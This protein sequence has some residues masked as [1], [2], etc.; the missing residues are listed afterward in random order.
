MFGPQVLRVAV[1][2]EIALRNQHPNVIAATWF[3]SSN[4]PTAQPMSGC[5]AAYLTIEDRGCDQ[6]PPRMPVKPTYILGITAYDHDVSACLLRDGEIAFGISK[7][8]LTRQKHATGFY[9]EAVD[10]CLD[11]EGIT[12]DDVDLVVRNCYV[13]PVEE[14]EVRLSHQEMPNYLSADGARRRSELSAL[15]RKLKQGRHGFASSRPRLQ[16]IRGVPVRR[17][18][19][20]GGGRRRQL[21]RRRDGGLSR[22]RPARSAGS[23]VGELLRVQRLEA[24]GAEENLAA[25]PPADFSATSSTACPA[26]ARFTA[27]RRATSSPTG[28]SAAS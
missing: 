1:E 20:D 16:R 25:I 15:P 6:W 12:L 5:N 4:P 9:K 8:R 24:Q 7:E 3:R 23:R 21:R 17:G 26:L 11:A 22:R 10:Y 13:L 18:R 2:V 19:G 14:M 27:A 28:T